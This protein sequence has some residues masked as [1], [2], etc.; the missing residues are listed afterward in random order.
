MTE[1][2]GYLDMNKKNL[3]HPNK[4]NQLSFVLFFKKGIFVFQTEPNSIDRSIA[5]NPKKTSH[6]NPQE[7]LFHPL[8]PTRFDPKK[9]ISMLF[10]KKIFFFPPPTGIRT[11]IKKILVSP[12]A[13]A[14]RAPRPPIPRARARARRRRRRRRCCCPPTPPSHRI[15]IGKKRGVSNLGIDKNP[16][17]I[18][19]LYEPQP[20]EPAIPFF[21]TNWS[22]VS[23][24]SQRVIPLR[25]VSV[26]K[27][28]LFADL[29]PRSPF[30]RPVS[31]FPNKNT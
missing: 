28:P 7:T 12:T 4:I 27:C 16:I 6:P 14:K 24:P 8:S 23:H 29:S 30:P 10:S 3:C 22:A 1:S 15:G 17:G 9:K 19:P 18:K 20:F 31:G 26:T 13:C 5:S 21:S 2:T 25:H 11:H